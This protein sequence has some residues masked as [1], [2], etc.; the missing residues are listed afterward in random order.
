M[1][2]HQVQSVDVCL[3]LVVV[4]LFINLILWTLCVFC[5]GTKRKMNE[6]WRKENKMNSCLFPVLNPGPTVFQEHRFWNTD[7]I[8]ASLR[9]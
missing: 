5:V 2:L 6:R 8:D 7:P 1:E 4:C 9:G 3:L